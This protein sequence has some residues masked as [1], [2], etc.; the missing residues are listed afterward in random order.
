MELSVLRVPSTAQMHT[1][2]QA[3]QHYDAAGGAIDMN[4]LQLWHDGPLLILGEWDSTAPSGKLAS[5]SSV[6][7]WLTCGEPTVASRE[8]QRRRPSSTTSCS[9]GH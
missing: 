9:R 1:G 7:E 2:A 4:A 8:S 3:Q 6:A 5:L